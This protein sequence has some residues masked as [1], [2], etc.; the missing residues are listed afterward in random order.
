MQCSRHRPPTEEPH[1]GPGL[2]GVSRRDLGGFLDEIAQR[3]QSRSRRR[4]ERR[5]A[6]GRDQR[7]TV[8]GDSAAGRTNGEALFNLHG[9]VTAHVIDSAEP[10]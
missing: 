2:P 7:Y 5:H 9:T 10:Y 3:I 4:L 6:V 1:R 8:A